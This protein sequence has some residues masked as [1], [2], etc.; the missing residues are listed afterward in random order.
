MRV[1]AF[2]LDIWRILGLSLLASVFFLAM[3]SGNALAQK[4]SH[5]HGHHLDHLSPFKEKAVSKPHCAL[6]KNHQT[7]GLCPH[8]TFNSKVKN[9]QFH[10]ATDCGGSPFKHAAIS[11]NKDHSPFL[12]EMLV[13]TEELIASGIWSYE[14]PHFD[15]LLIDKITPPPRLHS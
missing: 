8:Q 15:S 9:T 4:A 6:H 12:L 7:S 1:K 2:S 10:L 5:N 14:P 3:G 11:F 13:Y